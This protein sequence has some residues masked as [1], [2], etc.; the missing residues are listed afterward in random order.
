MVVFRPSVGKRVMVGDGADSGFAGAEL[1]PVIG[2]AGAER[3]HDA[4][5]GHDDDRPAEFIA[6]CSHDLS[7]GG[8]ALVN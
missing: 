8:V 2:F 7:V 4:H 6:H 3:G 5:A 1:G